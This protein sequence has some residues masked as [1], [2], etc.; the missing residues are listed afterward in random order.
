[1]SC[2]PDLVVREFRR[3]IF[4]KRFGQCVGDFDIFDVVS[5]NGRLR[6]L[7]GNVLARW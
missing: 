5:M 7:R 1:M 6:P 3:T 4:L 2:S